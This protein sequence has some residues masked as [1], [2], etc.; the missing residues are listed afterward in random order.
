MLEKSTLNKAGAAMK[1]AGAKAAEQGS[2]ISVT[3]IDQAEANAREAFA[4]LRRASQAKSLTEVMQIQGDYIREQGS[5][6]MNQAR[7]IG[8][9]IA[10]FGRETMAP[11]TGGE[12]KNAES[13]PE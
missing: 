9:L 10:R 1:D 13:K 11:M 5:R 7:E 6:S 2:A 4:A 3:V 12:N 8:E